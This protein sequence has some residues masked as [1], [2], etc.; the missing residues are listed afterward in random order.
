[1]YA[2]DL[3]PYPVGWYCIGF[4]KHLRPGQHRDV[5]FMGEQ[6]I[7]HRTAA[8]VVRFTSAFCPHLGAHLGSG[9][10]DGENFRCPFHGFKFDGSG[11]CVSNPYGQSPRQARLATFEV[12]ESHGLILA[13]HG[14]VSWR[15][16][17]PSRTW[18]APS[19]RIFRFRG[20][21]QEVIENG[22]DSG[23]LGFI[24]KFADVKIL[25]D[26]AIQG[27]TL[28]ASYS[29]RKHIPLLRQTF[30]Y[31]VSYLLRWPWILAS[32]YFAARARYGIHTM[33]PT[34]ACSRWPD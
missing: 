30:L 1:M 17:F 12:L 33:D 24:H 28:T 26:V 29:M 27:S 19:T 31:R 34:D 7:V 5:T 18:P 22:V 25:E 4:S 3:P 15:P 2:H 20:H 16:Q 11:R 21:P 9:S 32:S 8:G 10:V 23:H 14:D 6:F 13:R